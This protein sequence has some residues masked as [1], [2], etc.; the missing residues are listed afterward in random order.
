[1][2]LALAV[3]SYST[4]AALEAV[5]TQAARETACFIKV[6]TMWFDMLNVKTPTRGI[7]QR[8]DSAQAWTPENL[9]AR[10]AFMTA[11]VKW[12]D[13]WEAT[14][15]GRGRRNACGALTRDTSWASRQTSLSTVCV[16]LAI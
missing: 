16:R 14:I 15:R 4:I 2:S 10:E 1:M 7:H 12:L 6:F 13:D 11:V 3:F 8:L 5:E 9:P